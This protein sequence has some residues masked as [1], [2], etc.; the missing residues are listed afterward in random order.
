MFFPKM[1]QTIVTCARWLEEKEDPDEVIEALRRLHPRS[2]NKN[3]RKVRLQWIDTYGASHNAGPVRNEL[4]SVA[5]RIKRETSKAKKTK[6]Q[7]NYLKQLETAEERVLMFAKLD[8]RAKW[9]ARRKVYSRKDSFTGLAE[10][11]EHLR[12]VQLLPDY[13]SRLE[14]TPEEKSIPRKKRR[15]ALEARCERGFVV[16]ATELLDLMSSIIKYPRANYFE[17]V[18]ALSFMSGRGLPEILGVAEFSPCQGNP[19]VAVVST[20][21][22]E[23]VV[24]IL[25][26]FE[27]FVKGVERIRG[28]KDTAHLTAA[29]L[30]QRF[31]KSA[32]VWARKIL[33]VNGEDRHTFSDLKVMHAALSFKVFEGHG[34][35]FG[36]GVRV[37]CGQSSPALQ[38]KSA[39]VT[40]EGVEDRLYRRWVS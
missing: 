16:N 19:H 6:G 9:S 40:V 8:L 37:A 20:G 2:L 10:V 34:L 15:E 25:C 12:K 23:A 22:V 14:L 32:N 13:V 28:M 39:T 29:E 38:K 1:D 11:D 35:G 7:R 3:V 4:R 27:E 5:K 31:S 18:C 17:L 24:P 30:N 33:P 26:E 36:E 21:A